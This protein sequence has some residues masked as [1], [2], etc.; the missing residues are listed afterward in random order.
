ME[1][2]EYDI[3]IR[4]ILQRTVKQR[5]R[6]KE[7]AQQIVEEKYYNQEIVL[8]SEDFSERQFICREAAL[9]RD[10]AHRR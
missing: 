9:A 1:E 10:A 8:D 4:E 3:T 7:E 5:A 2:R 6:S